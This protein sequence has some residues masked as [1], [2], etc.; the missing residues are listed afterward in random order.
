MTQVPSLHFG[1]TTFNQA[2][3]VQNRFQQTAVKAV[4]SAQSDAFVRLHSANINMQALTSKLA[5]PLFSS[6]MPS[7]HIQAPQAKR[8]MSLKF[9]LLSVLAVTSA[10]RETDESRHAIR[11]SE[12]SELER[13]RAT[14]ITRQS[15]IPEDLELQQGIITKASTRLKEIE[16]ANKAKN[17]EKITDQASLDEEERA[18]EEEKRIAEKEIQALKSEQE[19]IPANIRNYGIRLRR[20]GVTE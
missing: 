20:L 3:P 16:N 2:A 10:H 14:L 13:N 15:K 1:A 12:I 11:T 6:N 18:L 5:A 4:L 19:S 17:K 8:D 7:M 9:G